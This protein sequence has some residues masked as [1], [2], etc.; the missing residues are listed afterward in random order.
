MSFL[1]RRSF[2]ISSGLAALGMLFPR[3][4]ARAGDVAW[5]AEVQRRPAAGLLDAPKLPPLLMDADGKPIETRN[6]WERERRRLRSAWLEFLGPMPAERPALGIEVLKEE[7]IRGCTRQ[8]LR[9]EAE[10]GLP[11]EGYLLR[12]DDGIPG[13]DAKTGKRAALVALHPT[14]NDTIEEIA[15]V[16]GD[17]GRHLALRLAR[18]GFVVFCPRCFL[19]QSVEQYQQAVENFRRRHPQ[20]LGMHKMLWDAMRGVDVLESLGSEIDTKRIG[21]VG[22][23]LG[24]KE[25]LYLA[26]FDERVAAAVASEGGIGLTFT[27]WDAVWY[28]GPGIKA[29]DFKLD[30]HQLLALIAPRPFLI[31]AGESGNGAADGDRTWPYVEAALEVYRLYGSPPRLGLYNH[32]EGHTISDATFERMA[33]WLTSYLA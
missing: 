22:H 21:A 14:S 11:V 5:L 29:A 10:A 15:G 6:G 13:R 33:Q 9:Y 16:K 8:L 20:T 31:L 30:H 26:A 4:H 1:D 18:R 12:P 28:L 27:N 17:E 32:R 25:T 3:Q 7:T 23:S 2:V 24:A 19:W